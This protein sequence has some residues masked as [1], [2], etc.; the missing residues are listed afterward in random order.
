MKNT[1][2]S[3]FDMESDSLINF[4]G[5][6]YYNQEEEIEEDEVILDLL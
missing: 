5:D 4:V 3:P 6:S 2:L 1:N